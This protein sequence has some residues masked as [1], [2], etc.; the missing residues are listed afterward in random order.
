MMSLERA[1]VGARY[2]LL[3]GNAYALDGNRIFTEGGSQ[4][5]AMPCVACH[6]ADGLGLAAAGFPGWRVCRRNTCAGNWRTTPVAREVIRDAAAGKR[7]H[8]CRNRCTE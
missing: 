3:L 2:G 5:G 6:G 7:A 1:L 4:P 8:R